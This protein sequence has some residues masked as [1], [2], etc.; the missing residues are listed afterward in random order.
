MK[1]HPKDLL[2]A[3][4]EDDEKELSAEE[5]AKKFR[6]AEPAILADK[7]QKIRTNDVKAAKASKAIYKNKDPR[8]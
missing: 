2:E 8:K 1:I 3:F 6:K 7:I 5:H 4:L